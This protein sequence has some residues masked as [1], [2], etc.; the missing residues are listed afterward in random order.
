MKIKKAHPRK[1][2]YQKKRT[3]ILYLILRALVIAGLVRAAFRREWETVFMCVLVLFLFLLPSIL[4]R[5]WKIEL[6][7]TLECIILLFIFAAQIL[8]EINN[9]YGRVPHWDT[10]L[11]TVNGFLCA[12]IGFALVDLFNRQAHMT[13][14]LSP[15]YLAIV[16]FCFSMTIG[17][18][19][20]FLEYS[21]DQFL[22]MDTQKDTVVHEIHSV[23]LDPQQQGHVVSLEGITDTAVIYADGHQELLGLGGYLDIGIHDTMK[24]LLVNFAGAVVFSFIGYYYVKN[25]GKGRF[26]ARFIPKVLFDETDASEK[27]EQ[28]RTAAQG[29]A[30]GKEASDRTGRE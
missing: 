12:A 20:E 17:V 9:F 2:P 24:D 16:A 6:P 3:L 23:M 19:W 18:L 1:Y 11:H 14:K 22:G 25:R 29:S 15:L 27:D 4:Q 7:S 8:G 28:S 21:G 30:G 10:A 13:F 26:A 5:Q